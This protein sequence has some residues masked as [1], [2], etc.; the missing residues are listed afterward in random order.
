MGRVRSEFFKDPDEM[1]F[2]QVCLPRHFIEWDV[3]AE[4]VIDEIDDCWNVPDVYFI[5]DAACFSRSMALIIP[6]QYID[7]PGWIRH[8]PE[9]S[10]YQKSGNGTSRIIVEIRVV[11]LCICTSAYAVLVWKPSGNETC[12]GRY[13]KDFKKP[14]H[15]DL[16]FGLIAGQSTV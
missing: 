5:G 14:A 16:S 3:L 7:R 4:V 1:E 2:A 12:P 13:V 10:G 8:D 11:L 15:P 6:A 9:L